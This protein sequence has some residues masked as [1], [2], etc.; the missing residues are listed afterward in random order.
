MGDTS[1]EVERKALIA[2]CR[3]GKLFE[4]QEWVRES[5]PTWS[6]P[7]TRKKSPL[8]TAIEVGFHSLVQVLLEAG[9]PPRQGN[10]IALKHAVQLRRPDLAELLLRFGANVD[11]V[12][13]RLVVERW[14]PEM[15]DLFIANGASLVH[16]DPVAWGLVNKIRPALGLLKQY[17]ASLPELMLQANLALRFHAD[18]GNQKWVSLTL[19]AGADP[20]ARGPNQLDDKFADEVCLHR[21]AVEILLAGGMVHLLKK[22]KLSASMGPTEPNAARLLEEACHAR[23]SESLEF[24]LDLGHKPADLPERGTRTITS[25]LHSMSWPTYSIHSNLAFLERSHGIDS[26]R[27]I[28]RMK[29][30]HMIVDAGAKWLPADKRTIADVR[31][32]LLKMAPQYVLEFV[33]LM[34]TYQAARK[35]DVRELLRTGAMS[36]RI[37]ENRSRAKELLGLPEEL[38]FDPAAR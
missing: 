32:S 31:R 23:D 3:Q 2:L 6:P 19:W 21:N 20:W 9:A 33:W 25:L 17:G 28:E 1:D 35:C 29:M 5:T 22:T 7:P 24:L 10:Y 16:H 11:D 34:N 26:H 14:H 12:P 13:M 18:E 15:I 4:V 36:R 27:S 30:L 37:S 8:R 38:P